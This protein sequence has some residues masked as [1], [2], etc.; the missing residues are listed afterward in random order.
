M[1]FLCSLAR[2]AAKNRSW[3]FRANVVYLAQNKY[4]T[5]TMALYRSEY[6][7]NTTGQHGFHAALGHGKG[8]GYSF[9]VTTYPCN[10]AAFRSAMSLYTRCKR[11]TDFDNYSVIPL[12]NEAY[13]EPSPSPAVTGH[14][15]PRGSPSLFTDLSLLRTSWVKHLF[16]VAS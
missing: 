11:R 4:G 5:P 6:K 9:N 12:S 1:I 10:S 14:T 3:E 7:T 2:S 16:A 15:S 8:S 13:S